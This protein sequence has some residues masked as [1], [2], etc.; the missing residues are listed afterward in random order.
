MEVEI[1]KQYFHIFMFLLGDCSLE[2][3]V[4]ETRRM[5]LQGTF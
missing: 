1:F 5:N 4:S 3:R 2:K